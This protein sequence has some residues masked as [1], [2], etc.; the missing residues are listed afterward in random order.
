M[1]IK[2]TTTNMLIGGG[3]LLGLLWYRQKQAAQAAAMRVRPR[4]PAGG[5][6]GMMRPAPLS[7]ELQNAVHNVEAY[8]GTDAARVVSAIDD[9][10][11]TT[12]SEQ[13]VYQAVSVIRPTSIPYLADLLTHQQWVLLSPDLEGYWRGVLTQAIHNRSAGG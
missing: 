5:G 10:L 12:R 4:S 13:E 7:P 9:L 11:H 8:V 1:K 2:L 6:G 3:V